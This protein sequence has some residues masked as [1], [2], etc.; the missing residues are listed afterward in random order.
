[1]RTAIRFKA[2]VLHTIRQTLNRLDFTEV[3][4]P[5]ARRTDQGA[6][7]RATAQLHEPKFLRTMIGPALRYNLQHL[8]RIYE[9]GPCFRLDAEDATHSA[10]FT[11]LDLYAASESFEFL[12]RLAE[13]LVAPVLGRDFERVSVARHLQSVFG[14]DLFE[15]SPRALEEKL[16]RHL[17][18][19]DR[20]PF[21]G[22]LERYVEQE[23]E[24]QS[25]GRAV[26]LH[27]FPLGGNEPC[28]RLMPGT[29][30]VL[31]RFELIVDGLEV[32]HGYEDEVD[33]AAFEQRAAQVGLLDAEQLLV[34]DEI[35][36]GRLPAASVGLGIGIERLCMAATGTTDM[37]HFRQSAAY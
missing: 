23:L 17:D 3:I 35:A 10:E 25:V 5:V 19:P 26:F 9:I 6:G 28:A 4:T 31:N 7:R 16:R 32:V 1:M 22:L 21:A 27:E 15:E 34:Q 12:F 8:P 20:V 36:Q 29:A 11:M 37:A 2:E 13:D 14:V 18:V 33:R 30:G 24:S